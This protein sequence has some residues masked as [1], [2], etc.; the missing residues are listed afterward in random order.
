MLIHFTV[1]VLESSN[2]FYFKINWQTGLVLTRGLLLTALSLIWIK[3]WGAKLTDVCAHCVPKA[4]LKNEFIQIR[5]VPQEPSSVAASE[6]SPVFWRRKQWVLCGLQKQGLIEVNNC[7]VWACLSC[8]SLPT[9]LVCPS[10]R[11]MTHKT[12]TERRT[13][14]LAEECFWTLSRLANR[15]LWKH[16]ASL[17]PRLSP[18][19]PLSKDTLSTLLGRCCHGDEQV[20][21]TWR[22]MKCVSGH[23]LSLNIQD[24]LCVLISRT[25][26]EAKISNNL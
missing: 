21:V 2:L 5:R 16:L 4:S 13:V 25:L 18:Q 10:E 8:C 7:I 23:G 3:G 20:L 11:Q 6:K 24:V 9:C 22:W 19:A 14:R 17:Q 1:K 12:H 26:I 15:L